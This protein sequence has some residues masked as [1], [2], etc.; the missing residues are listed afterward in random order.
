MIVNNYSNDGNISKDDNID[1]VC[2]VYLREMILKG[3]D[4]R[5]K[6]TASTIAALRPSQL[7]E[8]NTSMSGIL[9]FYSTTIFQYTFLISVE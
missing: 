3:G 4:T 9:T 1:N 2:N 5:Q 6:K 8:F 7:G